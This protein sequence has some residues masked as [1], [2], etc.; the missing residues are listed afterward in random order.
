MELFEG[1]PRERNLLIGLGVMLLALAAW[2]LLAGREPAA[3]PTADRDTALQTALGDLQTVESAMSG[4]TV[5]ATAQRAP[6]DRAALVRASQVAGL[7]IS[8]LQNS[9]DGAFTVDI[10]P[11]PTASVLGFLA[12]LTTQTD[13]RITDLDMEAAEAPFVET[14]VTLAPG[15]AP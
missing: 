8:R 5:S 2:F 3:A 10:A 6:F 4:R 14:R 13:A 1:T 15:A 9:G 7:T 12:T 11:A